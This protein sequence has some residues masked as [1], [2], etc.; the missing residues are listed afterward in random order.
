MP[1]VVEDAAKK[2]EATPEDKPTTTGDVGGD[3]GDLLGANNASEDKPEGGPP[4]KPEDRPSGLPPVLSQIPP[5]PDKT[6]IDRQAAKVESARQDLAA[7]QARANDAAAQDY[8]QGAGAGPGRDVSDPLTQEVFDAR[9]ELTEQTRILNELNYASSAHGG[10]TAPVAPLPENAHVQGLP[11]E[12][13]VIEAAA[14]AFAAGS[15]DAAKTVWDVTMPDVANMHEVATNW[16]EAS[17]ADRIQAG[18]DAAGMVPLPG[19]KILGEGIEHGIDALGGATRHVDDVPAQHVDSPVEHSTGDPAPSDFGT[20]HLGAANQV[21]LNMANTAQDIFTS[22]GMD[23]LR[24]AA[25]N[26]IAA[27]VEINGYKVLYEPDIPGS[28]FS[29]ASFG[30]RGFAI[31]PQGMSSD[32]ELARTVAHEVYRVNM[33]EIPELGVDATRAASETQAAFEF[34]EKFGETFLHGGG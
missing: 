34:A 30:E 7:A 24:H 5:P 10:P 28:G 33:T 14:E 4:G 18:L 12:P 23:E 19:A 1:K 9:A 31:G 3:L 21:E 8:T 15:K 27:E 13:P 26:G 16:D 25:Q 6:A 20:D 2:S 11:P 29:L 17:T 22:P 32:L